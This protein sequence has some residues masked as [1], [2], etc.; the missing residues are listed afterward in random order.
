MVVPRFVG[1]ELE[2]V[3]QLLEQ[4][5]LAAV[6]DRALCVLGVLNGLRVAAG[7]VFYRDKWRV[8]LRVESFDVLC[9]GACQLM[10]WVGDWK[11]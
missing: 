7:G 11:S 9:V 1:V 3:V 5:E 8:S 6:L 10:C 4:K 2:V